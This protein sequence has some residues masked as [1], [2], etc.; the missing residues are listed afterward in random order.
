MLTTAHMV[1]TGSQCSPQKRQLAACQRH[2]GES[3]ES[4]LIAKPC[5]RQALFLNLKYFSFSG[6][7]AFL[8]TWEWDPEWVSNY[9]V[10]A[11]IPNHTSP[12]IYAASLT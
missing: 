12:P 7:L 3:V 5:Q 6:P 2:E 1:F 4:S 8:P 11:V 10:V 9:I